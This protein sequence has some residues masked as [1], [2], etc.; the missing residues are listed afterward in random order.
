MMSMKYIC[1]KI[2][3]IRAWSCIMYV[4]F[5]RLVKLISVLKVTRKIGVYRVRA[6]SS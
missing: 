6:A 1:L 4:L 5:C 3:F 2:E